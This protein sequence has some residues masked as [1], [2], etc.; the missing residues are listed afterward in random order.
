[1]DSLGSPRLLQVILRKTIT[2][3][4][5]VD[6]IPFSIDEDSMIERADS[7]WELI[8]ESGSE[9]PGAARPV[10]SEVEFLGM[11]PADWVCPNCLADLVVQGR[12][13]SVSITLADN[14]R[15]PILAY[16]DITEAVFSCSRAC[17]HSLSK[18][19]QEALL[20]LLQRP[21]ASVG[22]LDGS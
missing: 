5:A 21:G 6:K 1:M 22:G 14:A 17:G 13:A 16:E 3:V 15:R 4:V 9:G 10:Y 18:D 8:P 2:A 11:H 12:L 20:A 19:K 7:L